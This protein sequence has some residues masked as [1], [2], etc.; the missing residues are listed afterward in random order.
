MLLNSVCQN[1]EDF[2]TLRLSGILVCS[3]LVVLLPGFAIK[4]MGVWKM[5][6]NVIFFL[7]ILEE[8]KKD[9]IN[10]LFLDVW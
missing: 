4:I 3:F 2:Y 6:V 10:S 7:T 8:F 9:G 5:S 1:V